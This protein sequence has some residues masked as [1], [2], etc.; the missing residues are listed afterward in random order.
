MKRRKNKAFTFICSFLPGAAEMY[1][2]LMK[3]GVSLMA[4][5]F[6]SF[7]LPAAQI[8]EGIFVFVAALVWFYGFFHARNIATCDEETFQNLEDQYIWEEFMGGGKIHIPDRTMR[9]WCAGILI[10]F[11]IMMLWQNLRSVIYNLI[12][13]SIW[14]E[15]YPLVAKVPQT[16][17][18]ILLILVGIRLIRGKKAAMNEIYEISGGDAIDYLDKGIDTGNATDSNEGVKAGVNGNA[19]NDFDGGISGNAVND[20]NEGGGTINEVGANHETNDESGDIYE[21]K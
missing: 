5:F 8:L 14:D 20:S 1:M 18:A 3:T 19:V 9:K 12:P 13:D 15:V 10:V 16:V 11:G 4:V 17:I 6:L 7:L 21:N 2:G